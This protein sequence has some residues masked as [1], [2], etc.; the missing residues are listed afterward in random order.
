M[1]FGGPTNPEDN[2][3]TGRY[4]LSGASGMLG[5]ALRRAFSARQA[6]ATE[7]SPVL[8]LVRHKRSPDPAPAPASAAGSVPGRPAPPRLRAAA[9][10]I[11]G[12]LSWDPT[13][14]QPVANPELLEGFTAAIHLGGANLISHKWTPD[15]KR[16]IASSRIGSTRALAVTLAA[17]RQP[18]KA[19]LVS[20]ATGIY[21]SR[22]DE[23]LDETAQPGSGFLA[24][25]CREWE[26]AA[27]PA[28]DAGIRVVHMR[29][30][31]VLGPVAGLPPGTL[32][33]LL[34]I[35]RWGLGGAIGPG[36]QWM[37]WIA[38]DDLVSAI[39][40]LLD[41]PALDGP[42]NLTAPE[43][44]TNR[45]FTRQ[46]ARAVHRP[47]VLPVPAGILRLKF[48]EFADEALL[49][50][51]RAYPG[52]LTSAGFKFDQPNIDAALAA[53]LKSK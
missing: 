41:H 47:A 33:H 36:T 18:P 3:L 44:V 19:L 27:Q 4:L 50:S 29:F 2:P 23:M 8:Q 28:V 15:Y 11:T 45:E 40:F 25:L 43:P 14:S 6:F 12:E 37:S 34:P 1:R 10:A 21:G 17:L 38:L 30:G 7:K 13:S 35:F 5:V 48:G 20:S 16:E 32:N 46:L 52:R 39:F 49:S 42:V 22:G 26:A 24:D 53:A 51:T 31:V 9:M